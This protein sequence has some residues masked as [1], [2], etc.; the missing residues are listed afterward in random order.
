MVANAFE[1]TGLDA[2][3]FLDLLAA[4]AL[5][6]NNAFDYYR[7]NSD[8]VGVVWSADA[9]AW[10]GADGYWADV[11][12]SAMATYALLRDGRYDAVA[13]EGLAW[14]LSQ[15]NAGGT[16]GTTQGTVFMLKSLALTADD[17]QRCDHAYHHPPRHRRA[18]DD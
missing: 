15:R 17:V 11:D 6:A 12:T 9:T 10:T 8:D 14:L 4:R 16:I 3:P 13:Q 5:P 18:G 1:A 2:K 7:V